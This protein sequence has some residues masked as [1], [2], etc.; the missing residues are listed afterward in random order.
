[1]ADVAT[2]EFLVKCKCMSEARFA[3]Y[4]TIYH[5]IFLSLS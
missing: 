4:L 1:M 3:K 5:K 2:A